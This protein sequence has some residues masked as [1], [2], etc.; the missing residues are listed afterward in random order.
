VVVSLVVAL[1]GKAQAYADKVNSTRQLKD[2]LQNLAADALTDDGEN[3]MA[4][5]L[6]FTPSEP[7]MILSE[8]DIVEDYPELLRL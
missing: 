4:V 1:R 2:C 3:I 5:E 8:R 7:G 6:L